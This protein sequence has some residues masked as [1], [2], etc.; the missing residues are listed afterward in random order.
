MMK[1]AILHLKLAIALHKK[2]MDGSAPIAGKEGE[3]SQIELMHHMEESMTF[4]V[5]HHKKKNMLA[6]SDS[7]M[8]GM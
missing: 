6:V 5:A 1:D 8:K 7:D 4:M 3:K 2:H